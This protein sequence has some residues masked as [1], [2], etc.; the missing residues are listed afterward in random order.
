MVTRNGEMATLC[1]SAF[2]TDWFG[3]LGISPQTIVEL[4]PFDGGDI[5]RFQAQYPNCRCV[6][7]EADPE[8]AA[9]VLVNTKGTEIE[10]V[11][12]AACDAN[13]PIN[14][15]SS[16]INGKADAQG[17]VYQ[18]SDKYKSRFSFVN[19]RDATT[20]NGRRLADLCA[21]LEITSIDLLHMDIEGAE[22]LALK[23]L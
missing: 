3:E 17:S 7:V 21:E 11:E 2:Q 14:W 4:G 13:G 1:H 9:I 10:V 5:S 22:Y 15:F 16:E 6:A 18:H 23:G 8:R 19:Q 12:A 20:V